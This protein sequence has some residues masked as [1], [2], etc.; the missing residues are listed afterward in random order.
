[1]HSADATELLNTENTDRGLQRRQMR[2]SCRA[3]VLAAVPKCI[4][5]FVDRGKR[6]SLRYDVS[7]CSYGASSSSSL[8]AA[9]CSR[10]L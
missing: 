9:V 3:C 2:S 7:S 5:V 10:L 8:V 1:M 6:D 4:N